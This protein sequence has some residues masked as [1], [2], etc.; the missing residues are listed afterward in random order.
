[1][2]VA[3]EPKLGFNDHSNDR[4]EVL[5]KMKTFEKHNVTHLS[6]SSINEYIANPAKW[7]LR[8][9]GYKDIF[10]NPAMWRGSATDNAICKALQNEDFTLQDAIRS[11]VEDYDTFWSKSVSQTEIDLQKVEAEK[12]SLA[13]YVQTAF[14]YYRDRP[15][16][17]IEIQKKISL[18]IDPKY[19]EIIGYID[20]LY[21]EVVCDM[22]TVARLP[23]E[24]PESVN[25]QLS[26][27]AYAEKKPA[28][29]DYVH[30]TKTSS[31]VVSRE[32]NDLDHH[33]KV[34]NQAVSSM[35][36]ILSFSDDIQEI[37]F[38]MVPNLDDWRWSPSEKQAAK[39]LWSYLGS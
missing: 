6:A 35:E 37:A 16:R 32:I 11:S 29:V 4:K 15:Y 22:K 21:E 25:R 34:V 10:G 31:Q 13:K 26:I 23:S 18:N 5:E 3:K 27:Y 8:V 30:C 33:F 20:F 12:S 28:I 9:S 24:T 39:K 1:M 17:P 2:D 38:L 36:K 14:E 19:P 7:V